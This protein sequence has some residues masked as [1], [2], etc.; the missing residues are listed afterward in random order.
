[1]NSSNV[2]ITRLTDTDKYQWVMQSGMRWR[3]QQQK[4][5]DFCNDNCNCHM[6]LVCIL[7][8]F[9]GIIAGFSGQSFQQNR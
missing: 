8:P 6:T 1:M 7:I 2:I 3:Q 9:D 4:L 5:C